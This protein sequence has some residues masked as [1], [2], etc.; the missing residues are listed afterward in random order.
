MKSFRVTPPSYSNEIIFNNRISRAH[1]VFENT[2]STMCL[3]HTYITFFVNCLLRK[4]FIC[5]RGH[6]IEN[7][8]DNIFQVHGRIT[9]NPMRCSPLETHLD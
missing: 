7:Q 1:R 3:R 4:L 9:H 8:I 6:L 5:L 2:L